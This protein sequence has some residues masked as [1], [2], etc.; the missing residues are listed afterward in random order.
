M[1]IIE[2]KNN[3]ND[4][5]A[6]LK[7]LGKS[8]FQFDSDVT[9]DDCLYPKDQSISIGYYN[10]N[11]VISDDYQITTQSLERARGL[12]LSPE[13]KGLV[14]LFPDSE[15]V[16][17]ACHS[18]VNY[19]GYSLIANG[20][21]VR[22]KTISADDPVKEAGERTPE[23]QAIYQSASQKN[24][25]NDWNGSAEDQLM[26]KFTFGFAKRRLGA[27]IDHQEGDELKSQTPFKKYKNPKAGTE[28]KKNKWLMYGVLILALVAWQIF[29]RTILK[30]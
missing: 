11:I 26:E 28:A 19:H 25:K 24:G 6:I 18:G 20:K 22:I 2:N 5:E 14:K 23:E 8:N 10:G 17:V 4:N 29:K 1:I 30:H 27:L 12:E 16:S 13:E 7:A 15:I 21:K 3:I 9:L